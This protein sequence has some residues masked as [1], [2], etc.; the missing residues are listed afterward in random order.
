MIKSWHACLNI[1]WKLPTIIIRNW[2]IWIRIDQHQSHCW[3]LFPGS[4]WLGLD[5]QLAKMTRASSIFSRNGQYSLSSAAR[6]HDSPLDANCYLY[7]YQNDDKIISI[8][9]ITYCYLN[10]RKLY[11]SGSNGH[12]GRTSLERGEGLGARRSMAHC[13]GRCLVFLQPSIHVVDTCFYN[14]TQVANIQ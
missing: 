7:N 13:S 1:T 14:L 10:Q 3:A 2:C 6:L 11:N 4:Q 5:M 12:N 8:V 9:R